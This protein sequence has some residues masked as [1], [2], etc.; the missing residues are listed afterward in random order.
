[1]RQKQKQNGDIGGGGCLANARIEQTAMQKHDKPDQTHDTRG[2]ANDDGRQ[3]L[4]GRGY[5][6]HLEQEYRGQ[7]TAHMSEQDDENADME[8]NTAPDE[9][10]AAQQLT[11][12]AAPGILLAIETDEAADQEDRQGN[13]G[14]DT[15]K[16]CVDPLAHRRSPVSG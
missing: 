6:N 10:T 2:A 16:E 7:Q 12:L 3:L 1:M 5:S 4:G 14:V 8:Q 15:E 13:I 11:R 9:L